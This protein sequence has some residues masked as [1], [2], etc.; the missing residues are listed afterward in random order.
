[1]AFP[2]VKNHGQFIRKDVLFRGSTAN[3]GVLVTHD[4]IE[5]QAQAEKGHSWTIREQLVNR[6]SWQ[7]KGEKTAPTTLNF[8]LGGDPSRWFRKLPTYHTV[9]LG[10]PLPGIEFSIDLHQV[11]AEKV[12][13]LSHGNLADKIVFRLEG[14]DQLTVN[15]PTGE[16]IL[17]KGQQTARFSSPVAFQWIDGKQQPVTVTYR[18]LDDNHYGFRLGAYDGSYPVTIDPGLV[19]STYLGGD[20]NDEY[21][22]DVVTN[23]QGEIYVTGK[24]G[25]NY[26]TVPFPT[27][28]SA[29]DK[30]RSG[31]EDAFV[32]RFSSDLK[33]LLSATF[34]GGNGNDHANGIHLGND[35]SLYVT[36]WTDGNG[37]PTTSGAFQSTALDG[38]A[39]FV[40]RFSAD[41]SQLAAST[42][43]DVGGWISGYD[44]TSDSSGNIYVSGAIHASSLLPASGYDTDPNGWND[45]LILKFSADLKNLLASTF[46][47]SGTDD[48]ANAIDIDSQGRVFVVGNTRVRHDD[49]SYTGFPTTAG[50]WLESPP[51]CRHAFVARFDADLSSLQKSTLIGVPGN[52]CGFSTSYGHVYGYD[53]VLDASGNPYIAGNIDTNGL[54]VTG[55]FQAIFQ[56][57]ADLYLLRLN[58][59]L[60][61]V[62]VAT[63]L[64]GSWSEDRPSLAL[65]PEG[66][67]F[68]SA[69]VGS[70][71]MPVSVDAYNASFNMG[72]YLFDTRDAWVAKLAPNLDRLIYGTFI[73]GTRGDWAYGLAVDSNSRMILV[74]Q[75][76]GVWDPAQ[77]YPVTQGAFDTGP[78]ADWAMDAFVSIFEIPQTLAVRV[79]GPANVVPG[80]KGDYVVRYRNAM[81]QTAEDVV[82]VVDLPL[83]LDV[84][85]SDGEGKYYTTDRCSNQIYWKLGDLEPDAAGVVSFQV[86]V[87]AGMPS[88]D[89]Q[90]SARIGAS[91]YAGSPFD[92]SVYLAH[93][94]TEAS[95]FRELSVSEI[96]TLLDSKPHIKALLDYARERHYGFFDKAS[97]TRFNT[98]SET[99][100]LYLTA[101]GDGAPAILNGDDSSAFIEVYRADQLLIF[102]ITGGYVWDPVQ[103]N[104]EFFGAWADDSAAGNGNLLRHGQ[105]ALHGISTSR[106]F[107]NCVLGLI[108]GLTWAK[109]HDLYG[110][111]GYSIDCIKCA[112]AV[113]NGIWNSPDC[114]KCTASTV[115]YVNPVKLSKK[116]PAMG[117]LINI[118]EGLHTC[119]NDCAKDPSKHVCQKDRYD[120]GCFANWAL[121]L[122][123]S[124][125]V[126]K[127]PCNTTTNTY[128]AVSYALYCGAAEKCVASRCDDSGYQSCCVPEDEYC[129]PDNPA[130]N[131]KDGS[132][133]PA[134]DPN[135]KLATPGGQVLAGQNI[136]YTIRYENTGAGDALGVFILDKLSE[137][138][139]ESTLV[140]EDGGSYSSDL[141]LLSWEIGDLAPGAKG[142]VSF[143]VKAKTNLAPGTEI[144]NQAEIYF[145]NAKEITPT[146]VVVHTVAEVTASD[147]HYS[148][149]AGDVLNIALEGSGPPPLS[150]E[151]LSGPLHG[152]LTGTPP[153]VT[154]TSSDQFS[155]IDRFTFRVSGGGKSSS[156]ADVTIEVQPGAETTAPTV[157]DH[158]PDDGQKGIRVSAEA[159]GNIDGEDVYAPSIR[160][161]FSEP[162][163]EATLKSGNFSLSGTSGTVVTWNASTGTARLWPK[164]PLKPGQT[165][166]VTLA[167]G[168]TDLA[169]NNLASLQH[170]SFTTAGNASLGV[171]FP[172]GLDHLNFGKVITGSQ[173]R[174]LAVLRNRGNGSLEITSIGISGAGFS[175]S[176]DGCSGR[177]LGAGEHCLVEVQF[178]SS[179]SGQHTGSMQV[180]SSDPTQPDYMA[181]LRAIVENPTID[182]CHTNPYTLTEPEYNSFKGVASEVSIDT[183]GAVTVASGGDLLLKAPAIHLNPFFKVIKGGLLR[184]QAGS[185]NCGK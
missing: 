75:T 179:T 153:G 82:L 129:P 89:F 65:G 120:C 136:T 27:T 81:K 138:L 18:L 94:P 6:T 155:G 70:G 54:P 110:V 159:I 100:K 40:S 22:I 49:S 143:Q 161:R 145:P 46:L 13:R 88:G 26:G 157:I 126:C 158:W 79:Q 141:R 163:D 119:Y 28:E 76:Q 66:N 160:V 11:Q 87:P 125:V 170:W 37:F 165:Y 63:Y 101:P 128:G 106:C 29:Y 16:L 92:V 9:S 50:V 185:V 116:L 20:S 104:L 14:V 180:K 1:M 35:G 133:R 21:A 181:E 31:E 5:Y 169:G 124:G 25:A 109:L 51:G 168:I 17:R 93:T 103:G 64:G 48:E 173:N 111:L 96:T 122:F 174:E 115:D 61:E 164:A 24:V 146:N 131:R 183:Q 147:D 113:K 90:L 149:T 152:A 127:T 36:G 117:D 85:P 172:A 98:G 62:Q 43:F 121:S 83:P 144:T 151:V 137:A 171:S 69:P 47:G 39:L 175:L 91:N 3:Y 167:T 58:A 107:F 38:N 162:I 44:I 178:G 184:I 41:L 72:A 52:T 130:C 78:L 139:D 123:H 97:Y 99:W 112:Q 108:P 57:H 2:F 55:G 177:T 148:I 10:S 34:L 84:I 156:P 53:L 60:S 71:D 134:H 140:I 80:T 95:E 150:Y 7:A 182:E 12:I 114:A 105:L 4:G 23:S 118:A 42:L 33:T 67:L 15:K 45:G 30:T 56:G 102:D 8:F 19:A 86:E 68:I 74:G 142:Q 154:Y 77:N 32:A 176:D 135:D 73:G 132:T 166:T 59:D